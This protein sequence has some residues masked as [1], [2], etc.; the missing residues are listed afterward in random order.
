ML[1]PVMMTVCPEKLSCGT[2]DTGSHLPVDKA[3]ECSRIAL[4]HCEKPEQKICT[5]K[6]RKR[7]MASVRAAGEH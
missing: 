3:A 6:K 4:C 2:G 5:S 1:D 7:R